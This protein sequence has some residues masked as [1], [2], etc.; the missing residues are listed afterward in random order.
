MTKQQRAPTTRAM[1]I[2]SRLFLRWM[3]SISRPK[4]GTFAV[5]LDRPPAEP[6]R[7]LR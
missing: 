2:V 3:P 1:I 5:R 4:P 6:V 7:E